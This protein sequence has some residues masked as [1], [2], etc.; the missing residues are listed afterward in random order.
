MRL[1][2]ITDVTDW[3]ETPVCRQRGNFLVNLTPVCSRVTL[4][5]ARR[6]VQIRN[7]KFYRRNTVLAN[8]RHQSLHFLFRETSDTTTFTI[9][10]SAPSPLK[11]KLLA[12]SSIRNF[13][14]LISEYVISSIVFKNCICNLSVV[15]KQKISQ[16]QERVRTYR[17]CHFKRPAQLSLELF[18]TG[19]NVSSEI[20]F[21]S[22]A[23]LD[24]GE[25]SLFF[26]LFFFFFFV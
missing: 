14:I 24:L 13:F 8:Y 17:V 2:I 21:I 18:V 7:F 3:Q 1:E 12:L 19:K 5:Q 11:K 25:S 10:T 4:V 23:N 16:S 22:I 15:F 9:F 6:H 20:Y 26:F